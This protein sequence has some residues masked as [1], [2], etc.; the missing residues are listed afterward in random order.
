MATTGMISTRH[1]WMADRQDLREK[2][3]SSP[4]LDFI[5]IHAYD[6]NEKPNEKEDD[7]DLAQRFTKPFIIEEAGF[8]KDKYP[9]RPEKT[10]QDMANWFK[11]GASCY[12][13]WGFMATDSDNG[14]SDN[15]VGM[16]R[17]FPDWGQMFELHRQCGEL[18]LSHDVNDS[19]G[20]AQKIAGINF[21]PR[22]ALPV[23]LPWP[24]LTD[25]F[26]FPVGWPDS[27]GYYMAAGLVDEAYFKKLGSWHTGEDW[28]GR[29][30]GDTDLGAPVY[31]IGNGLVVTAQRYPIWG[32]VVLLEHRL[33]WGHTI[34]SQYAH[35]KDCYV[36]KGDVLR[37]GEELGTIGKGDKDQFVAHLLF[38][39]R[40]KDLPASTWWGKTPA[41][42]E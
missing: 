7:S 36:K 9:N 12:M 32:N 1:A 14:D 25:G 27:L 33:P 31:T 41:D 4:N 18:I 10:R 5:T 39:V 28:N 21:T 23:A 26:D 24:L 35:L 22:R 19:Q 3:Y 17:Q 34:W 30:G 6:G 42:R 38:E 2:L 16:G 8:N 15:I 11:Q 20:L 40:V 29:G 37:R 13:P